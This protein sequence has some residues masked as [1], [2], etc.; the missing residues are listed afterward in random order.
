MGASDPAGNPSPRAGSKIRAAGIGHMVVEEYSGLLLR[1]QNENPS[2]GIFD[3]G[4]KRT[5][6]RIPAIVGLSVLLGI[7]CYQRD[8]APSP[9]P[10]AVLTL[11]RPTEVQ[12]VPSGTGLTYYGLFNSA[13]PWAVHL[14]RMELAQCDLRVTVLEAPVGSGW[15]EGRSPVSEMLAGEGPEVLAAVNG[16]FFTPEGSPIGTEVAGGEVRRVRDRPAIAWHPDHDPWMGEPRLEGDSVLLVGWPVSL[17]KGDGGTEVVG[18]FP[19]LLREGVRVGDLEVSARP[20]F[21]A[22]RHPRTAVGFD[23]DEGLLWIL[24]VDGRQPDYS[25]GMTLPELTDLLEAL[26]SEEAL[27]LDGGGSSVMVV[28]GRVVSS[29]SDTDGER[30]VVNALGIRRDPAFCSPGA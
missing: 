21:A 12:V 4:R 11:L 6:P 27:N 3:P 24:V 15:K 14:L 8:E 20:S 9:P 7:G 25:V 17:G 29:P 26:G 19:L 5:L 23:R 22:E 28:N 18:G 16:D 10:E 2:R 30:P 13:V 1:G